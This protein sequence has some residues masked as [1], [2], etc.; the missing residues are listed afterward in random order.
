VFKFN[1]E[2]ASKTKFFPQIDLKAIRSNAN[3][4]SARAL[5]YIVDM[6]KCEA[7]NYPGENEAA[8]KLAER[9]V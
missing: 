9:Y 4:E 1:E 2:L 6:A 8:E 3:Q 5:D 7:L